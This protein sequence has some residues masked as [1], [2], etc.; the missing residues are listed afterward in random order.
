MDGYSV[1]SVC[2]EAAAPMR[3][4]DSFS[5]LA[6]TGYAGLRMYSIIEVKKKYNVTM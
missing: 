1:F 5:Y 4:P 2:R 3:L 6:G